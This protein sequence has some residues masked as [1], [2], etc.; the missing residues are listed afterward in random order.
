MTDLPAR[1]LHR[2]AADGAADTVSLSYDARLLRRKRLVSDGGLAFVVDLPQTISVDEGDA[3]ELTDG[4]LIAVAAAA[5][6]L[7]EVTAPPT[8]LPRIAWHIGNRHTP[9]QILPGGAGLLIRAEA[10]M[11]RMLEG[12]GAQTRDIVAPFRP[13]GG[14]YGHGRTMGHTHGDHNHGDHAQKDHAHAHGDHHHDA[15]QHPAGRG[16]GDHAS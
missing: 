5:E 15:G 9:A 4:R 3:F 12:L 16:R 7:I 10:V 8:D 13:E 6:D 11:R 14:A 1:T 2:A